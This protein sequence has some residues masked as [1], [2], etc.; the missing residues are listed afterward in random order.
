MA[1][2][3]NP[4]MFLFKVTKLSLRKTGIL[5]T[6]PYILDPLKSNQK[7]IT[8]RGVLLAGFPISDY[9][10]LQFS[11]NRQE[12]SLIAKFTACHSDNSKQIGPSDCSSFMV[13]HYLILL[14]VA[15]SGY[16]ASAQN[17]A[18]GSTTVTF[19]DPSRSNR[20]IETDIY[21]PA[22]TAGSNTTFATG[23]FPVIVFGHGFVMSVA[24]Y[25]NIWSSLVPQGYI[26]ALPKTEGSILPNHTNFGRDLAYVVSALQQAG[27]TGGNIFNGKI[28]ATSAVMGHSMGGG[29][30][31]LSVQYNASITVV[32]G[33]APA[34]TNPSA[35][36]AAQQINRPALI[37]A[38]GNDCVTPASQHSRLIYDNLTSSCKWYLSI[39]GGSHCQFANQNFNCSFG[40]STCSPSP[41]INRTTQQLLVKEYLIPWLDFELK[42][43]CNPWI[44]L[45]SNLNNDSRLTIT[46]SCT[47]ASI[48]PA[49]TNRSVNNIK[50]TSAQFRWNTAECATGYE[51]KYRPT[52]TTI[53]NKK[54]TSANSRIIYNLLPGT[55]YEWQVRSICDSASAVKSSWGTMRTFTTLTTTAE[56]V[57]DYIT[58]SDFQLFPN[59]TSGTLTLTFEETPV[60]SSG[61]IAIYNMNGQRVMQV[62]FNRPEGPFNQVLDVTSLPAGLYILRFSSEEQVVNRQFTVR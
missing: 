6:R 56:K 1:A 22:T 17:F 9:T 60:L 45:Q 36:A 42:S 14:L 49:P 3:P 43:E 24:A 50:T 59:P 21:Y 47:G 55:T 46:S 13:K 2:S 41:T 34:E 61:Q 37:F 31:M 35:S 57:S 40:E 20:A 8:T 23:Q 30:A 51:V 18:I 32:A 15:L 19:N 11:E 53:W 44:L 48:C 38:G 54:L 52:G 33:L 28:A 12:K 7:Y 27:T 10:F 25:Q 5:C 39:N 26:V 62:N 29:A 4:F 58:S 16:S